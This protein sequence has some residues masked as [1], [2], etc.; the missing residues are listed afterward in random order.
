ENRAS[1]GERAGR[2]AVKITIGPFDQRT[3]RRRGDERIEFVQV[4]IIAADREAENDPATNAAIEARAVKDAIAAR[5]QAALRNKTIVRC[6]AKAVH[7]TESRPIFSDLEGGS[8]AIRAPNQSRSIEQA[9]RPFDDLGPGKQ[10][11]VATTHEF[12]QKN[13]IAAILA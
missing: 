3:F 12:V 2:R 10:S 5:E 11:V 9:V 13:V 7:Q 4:C 8:A 6:R 1:V